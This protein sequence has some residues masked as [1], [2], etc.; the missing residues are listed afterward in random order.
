MAQRKSERKSRWRSGASTTTNSSNIQHR[1]S[2]QRRLWL[3]TWIR[4][5]IQ[6]PMSERI[7]GNPGILQPST[8]STNFRF[9]GS[10]DL[11]RFCSL[12]GSIPALALKLNFKANVFGRNEGK[13]WFFPTTPSLAI[14]RVSHHR[15]CIDLGDS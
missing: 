15:D 14:L 2:T 11:T 13:Q 5:G 9:V 10:P 1:R 8:T 12:S 4:W 6:L 3:R 7:S